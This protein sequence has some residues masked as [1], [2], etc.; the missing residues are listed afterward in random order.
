MNSKTNGRCLIAPSA[1]RERDG[2]PSRRTFHTAAD[3]CDA[4]RPS[5]RDELLHDLVS[6]TALKPGGRRRRSASAA[7]LPSSRA[8]LRHDQPEPGLRF[9]VQAWVVSGV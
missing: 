7:S 6:L 9:A 5:Y 3:R 8:A 4:A 1:S 2:T